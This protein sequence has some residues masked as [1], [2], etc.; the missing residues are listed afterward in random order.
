ML[1]ISSQTEVI[2]ELNLYL[3]PINQVVSDHPLVVFESQ[4][5][6]SLHMINNNMLNTSG[7]RNE[8]AS[9][10]TDKLTFVSRHK[11]HRLMSLFDEGA[12]MFEITPRRLSKIVK[13]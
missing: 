3:T 1:V 10:I 4:A 2:C 13:N 5:A 7:R 9:L 6:R 12:I 8:M 11:P